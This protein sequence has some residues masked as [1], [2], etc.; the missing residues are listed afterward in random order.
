[1]APDAP[2]P[3]EPLLIPDNPPPGQAPT[4]ETNR[5]VQRLNPKGSTTPVPPK[6]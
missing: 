3:D 5:A 2:A 6:P 1:M 4:L